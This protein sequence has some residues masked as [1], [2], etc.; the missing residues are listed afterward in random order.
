MIMDKIYLYFTITG[1]RHRLGQDFF[2]K[3]MKVELVKEPNNEHDKEAIKVM[4]DGFHVGYVANSTYTVLEG[5]MSAGRIYDKV[6]D[7]A[8]GKV[9]IITDRGIICKLT[10]KSLL[11][12]MIIYGPKI[13]EDV[14]NE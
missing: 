12:N 10:K 1:T 13:E 6:G 11:E 2:K 14:V 9:K 8:Y 3:G 4:L 5:C 7:V